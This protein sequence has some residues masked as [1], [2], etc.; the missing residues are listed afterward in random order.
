MS[1][2]TGTD[3]P[4]GG[5]VGVPSELVTSESML[6]GMNVGSSETARG[7]TA[8]GLSGRTGDKL[9]LARCDC[10]GGGGD[11]LIFR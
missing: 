9:P 11:S 6:S 2:A 10:G 4:R 7:E 5:G 8:A 1:F 3:R